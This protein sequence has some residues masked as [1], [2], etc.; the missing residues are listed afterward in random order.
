MTVDL[1]GYN[2][3]GFRLDLIYNV[4]ILLTKYWKVMGKPKSV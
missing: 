1:G 4:N 2:M 3:D